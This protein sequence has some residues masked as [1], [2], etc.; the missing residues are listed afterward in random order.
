MSVSCVPELPV[1]RLPPFIC[2]AC[3]WQQ[4]SSKQGSSMWVGALLEGVQVDPWGKFKFLLMRVRD[5]NTGRQVLLVRGANNCSESGIVEDLHK[6]VRHSRSS[7]DSSGGD[8]SSSTA[9]GILGVL[10]QQG[11]HGVLLAAAWTVQSER[12][13]AERA[14]QAGLC[15]LLA[16]GCQHSYSSPDVVCAAGLL[17]ADGCYLQR[18]QPARRSS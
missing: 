18:A 7:G 10:G 3:R 4:V 16:A 13:Q 12:V 14:H 1:A 5:R 15:A 2:P 9:W 11:G 8:S 6:Q 17:H